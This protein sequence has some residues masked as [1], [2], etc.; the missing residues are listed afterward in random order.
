LSSNFLEATLIGR[1]SHL[2]HKRSQETS[3]DSSLRIALVSW[4]PS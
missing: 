1:H 4:Q 3:R 2:L